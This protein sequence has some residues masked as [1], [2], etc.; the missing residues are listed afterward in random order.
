VEPRISR[1]RP[2]V[3]VASRWERSL[4]DVRNVDA[5]VAVARDYLASLSPELLGRLPEDCRPGLIKYADD[6]DYWAYRLSQRYRAENDQPV[7][8]ELLHELLDFFLHALIRLAELHRNL[9]GPVR[10][11]A[12]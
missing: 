7:D 12:Q 1:P 4:D 9:P 10:I 8:G 6:I 3:K 11:K 5:I 2:G